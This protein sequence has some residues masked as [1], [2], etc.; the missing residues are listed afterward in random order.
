MKLI[1]M[2][3]VNLMDSKLI[4]PGTLK[5]YLRPPQKTLRESCA[6]GNCRRATRGSLR[7]VDPSRD[8]VEPRRQRH[9]CDRHHRH[10]A[11]RLRGYGLC[12]KH[13]RGA[14]RPPVEFCHELCG[15]A[16][17][18]TEPGSEP[19]RG[20]PRLLRSAVRRTLLPNTTS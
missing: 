7:F 10:D 14:F 11:C 15:S 18:I 9:A 17:P 8:P 12:P 13:F 6:W 20:R 4:T 5:S 3:D 16:S 19:F 2:G 1:L